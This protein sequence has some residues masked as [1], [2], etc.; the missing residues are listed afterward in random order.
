DRE[1]RQIH[2]ALNALLP[3]SV[4]VRRVEEAHADF[5]ARYDARYKM[6]EYR[7]WND[8]VHS[9]L[10]AVRAYHV[11]YPLDVKKMRRGAGL[12]RGR[13]DFRSFSGSQGLNGKGKGK[14]TVRT[15]RRFQVLNRGSLLIFRIEADGFLNHMVR[16][17]IGTLIEMGR[18]R[19]DGQELKRIIK[20]KDRRAAGPSVPARGLTLI[21]VTY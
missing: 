21:S 1:A 13:H 6:Y 4:A 7:I 5:H 2:K 20:Q 19:L 15:I 14:N 8:P 10:E 18:G 3:S 16:N 17:L 12:L 11:P 9:P